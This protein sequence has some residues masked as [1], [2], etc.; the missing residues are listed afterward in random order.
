MCVYLTS[1]EEI[2]EST[3]EYKQCKACSHVL[4]ILF[5][6]QKPRITFLIGPTA[7]EKRQSWLPKRKSV[8]SNGTVH[9]RQP[10]LSTKK[11]EEANNE[12]VPKNA[13]ILTY[14]EKPCD[15]PAGCF[16]Y[17]KNF[18]L[19]IFLT[20]LQMTTRSFT[21]NTVQFAV[22]NNGTRWTW[23]FGPGSV[24]LSVKDLDDN[25]RI[26][27]L[28][29]PL[30]AWSLLLSQRQDFLDNHLSRV[31]I[32]PNEQETFELREE[33]ISNVGAQDTATRGYELYDLEDIEFSSEDPAVDLARVFWPG[34][35][36]QL[37]ISIFDDFQ[38]GSTA[39]NIII[40]DDKEDKENSAPT[41][42]TPESERPTET[43][44]LL[45]SSPFG[46]RLEN[47]PDSVYRTLF[48]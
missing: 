38:M 35:D 12:S 15:A 11:A 14:K 47:A 36:T 28:E 30:A 26:S 8:A 37:S 2:N 3:Y 10:K 4:N 22:F 18:S 23:A 13:K 7:V 43:S 31:P 25:L 39:A 27:C 17:N 6:D 1:F 48:R 24:V 40:V 42:I 46:T 20:F 19:F 21:I 5:K 29:I 44:R 45:R 16:S 41:I 32:T 33:V 34:I 9:M